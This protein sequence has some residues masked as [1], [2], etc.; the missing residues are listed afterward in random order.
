[1]VTNKEGPALVLGFLKGR[2]AEM[3]ANNGELY[4]Y[5]THDAMT[6]LHNRRFAM[7]YLER[8]IREAERGLPLSVI[9]FDIDYFKKVNDTYGHP[10]GDE[11]LK[12]V[13]LRGFLSLRDFDLLSR[14]GGEEFLIVLPNTNLN[15]A[16]A[17]AER[18][19]TSVANEPIQI[20]DNTISLAISLGVVQ[21]VRGIKGEN[22]LN[23]AD[24]ALYAA[25]NGD[26]NNMGRNITA[27]LDTSGQFNL[28]K[29]STT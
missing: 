21:Y 14:W 13:A 9:M 17:I 6:G 26:E 24:Q 27:F 2:I 20:S 1:M 28:Y 12:E 7:E 5:A 10:V 15:D 22:I 3:R 16:I 19:R 11:V 25:K 23:Q 4:Y 8:E 18:I 29:P